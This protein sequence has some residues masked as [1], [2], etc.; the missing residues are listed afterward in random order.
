MIITTAC[1]NIENPFVIFSGIF[2]NPIQINIENIIIGIKFLSTIITGIP[3]IIPP[4]KHPIGIVVIPAKIPF[5]KNGRSSFS[6]IPNATGIVNTIVG[7]I[8]DPK[9]N[10][11]NLAACTSV[12]NLNA[13]G[14]PPI[15]VANKVVANI[16]GSAPNILYIGV[17]TGFNTSP[18]TG[19]NAIIP[20]IAKAKDPIAIIPSSNF[21]P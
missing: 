17:T 10:E 19:A 9:I 2:H 18:K 7:P 13:S 14:V 6:I 5:A 16:E 11:A 4:T 21:S 12:V 20:T 8:I 3:A 15:S 1:P